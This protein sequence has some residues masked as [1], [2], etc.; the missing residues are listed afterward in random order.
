MY[1]EK[2]KNKEI[3]K[4]K[5]ALIAGDEEEAKVLYKYSEHI[6]SNEFEE[7]KRSFKK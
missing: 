6:T 3:E 1:N 4:I 2:E 5:K 7:I